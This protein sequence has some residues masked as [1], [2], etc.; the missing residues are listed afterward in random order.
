MQRRL[1][2]ALPALSCAGSNLDCDAAA[3]ALARLAG[4]GPGLT[5]SGDDFIV[6]Y[7]AALSSRRVCEPWLWP[8]LSELSGPVMQFALAANLISRQYLL[9]ALA[10]EFP[11]S[12][13]QVVVGIAGN[14]D[15]RLRESTARLVRVGHSS[16][17][18]S[19]LGLLF[20]LCPAFVL[21][22]PAMADLAGPASI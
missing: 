4:L 14:D 2:Q 9:N 16:G 3:Q 6:G 17:A 7:L 20:G 13:A 11:E 21:A 15:L 22:D 5:P 12:L 19:L 1:R 8:Y 10:G 18:D